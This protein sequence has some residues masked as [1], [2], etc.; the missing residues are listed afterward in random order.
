MKKHI[1]MVCGSF[2]AASLEALSCNVTTQLLQKKKKK[3]K[4]FE[5]LGKYSMANVSVQ[6]SAVDKCLSKARPLHTTFR[7]SQCTTKKRSPYMQLAPGF[8]FSL[9]SDF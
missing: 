1:A 4:I 7:L 9:V 2:E 6:C 8:E 5:A 3:K